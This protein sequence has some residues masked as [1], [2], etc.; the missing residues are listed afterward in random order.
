[1]PTM[2]TENLQLIKD[3]L[4][5]PVIALIVF[6]IGLHIAKFLGRKAERLTRIR[7]PFAAPIVS[8]VVF[9]MLVLFTAT[10]AAGIVNVNIQFLIDFVLGTVSDILGYAAAGIVFAIAW[11]WSNHAQSQNAVNRE[12]RKLIAKFSNK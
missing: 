9:C 11:A 8:K 6:L 4:L 7:S 5:N 1:M 3:V 2:I 12:V 10:I